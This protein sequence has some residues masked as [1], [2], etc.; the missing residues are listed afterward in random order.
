MAFEYYI[1]D[2]DDPDFSWDQASK[3][4]PR[5]LGADLPWD[6]YGLFFAARKLPDS[7]QIDHLIYLTRLTC[8]DLRNLLAQV[9][10]PD[11][12]TS[13]PV[14]E[15]EEITLPLVDLMRVKRDLLARARELLESLPDDRLLILVALDM[16]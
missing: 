11:W 16:S 7:K 13:E 3:E 2:A 9:Y 12:G 5:P 4:P 6:G 1:A 15:Q 14:Q 10:G 8:A